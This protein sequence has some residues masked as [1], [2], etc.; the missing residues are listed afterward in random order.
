MRSLAILALVLGSAALVACGDA[1][2]TASNQFTGVGNNNNPAG[3]KDGGSSTDSGGGGNDSGTVLPDSGISSTS[4]DVMLDKSASDVELRSSVDIQVTVAPKNFTGTV[5]LDVTGL[6]AGITA[7]FVSASLSV[8]GSAGQTTM[9]TL[10]TTSSTAINLS[11]LMV[12]GTAGT[13]VATAPLAITV[14][15]LITILIPMNVDALKGTSGNPSTN[16]FGDFPIVITAPANIANTPIE[17]KFMNKDSAGHCIHAS[18]PGQGFAHD[19]QNGGPCAALIQ[20]NGFSGQVRKIT[21]TG[22]YPF[23]LHDQG[24]LTDGQIKI[25]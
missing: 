5:A 23:Y 7:K 3:N 25:Q 19:P 24:N 9:M 18:N 20:Q 22:N 13:N 2:G 21:A 14:K 6:P 8:T 11:S 16:V 17:V 12:R 10:T 1:G 4:F 15:P